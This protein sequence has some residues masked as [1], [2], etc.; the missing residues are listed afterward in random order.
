LSLLLLLSTG[1]VFNFGGKDGSE[2]SDSDTDADSDTDSDSDSDTDTDTDTDAD[3]DTDVDYGYLQV[4]NY[5]SYDVAYLYQ[6]DEYGTLY[7]L[8]GGNDLGYGD[9]E[10]FYIQANVYWQTFLVSD[11]WYCT[12][13][14]WYAVSPGSYQYLDV[15]D[16]NWVGNW[17]GATCY[18]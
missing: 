9:A 15:Y 14:D 4:T 6:Q 16:A 5:S 1:C 10:A 13:T 18:Y 2:E 3:T 11:E 7:E 8:L 12:F 17:D